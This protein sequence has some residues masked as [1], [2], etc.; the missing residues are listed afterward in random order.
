MVSTTIDNDITI[1]T[2]TP[3][4]S[5]DWQDIKRWLLLLSLPAIII[6]IGWLA[7][8]IWIILPFAGLEIALLSYFMYKVCYHNY[9]VEQI[10]INNRQVTLT[11]GIHSPKDTT[12]FSRPDCYL[13]V[14]K[15]TSPME[16]LELSLTS[17]TTSLPIGNFL[18]IEDREIARHALLK[19]GLMECSNR[20]WDKA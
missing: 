12:S 9:R 6:A 17:E 11:T 18:N 15:P 19:A 20:W 7:I 5:A 16:M 2:L 13:S 10:T 8:G 1:I 4:R 14:K 3:N